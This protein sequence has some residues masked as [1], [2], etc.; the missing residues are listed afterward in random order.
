LRDVP[1]MT[2]DDSL[3]NT[4]LDTRAGVCLN[5]VKRNQKNVLARPG[6]L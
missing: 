2:V 5:L 3:G 4:V 6:H 1:Q